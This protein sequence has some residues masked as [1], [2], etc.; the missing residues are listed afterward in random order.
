MTANS[1]PHQP[2]KPLITAGVVLGIGLG[3]FL[4][5]IVLHQ[6]LQVHGMLTARYPKD[7]IANLQINMF[8]DGIFHLVT[9]TMTVLGLWLLWRAATVH[10]VRMNGAV[11]VGAMFFGWGLFNLV[12]GIVDHH[13][14]HLHHVVEEHGVS[15]FDYAFLA[16]AVLMMVGGGLVI[17]RRSRETNP[18]QPG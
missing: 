7:S 4:D 18:S 9:W 5:G 11:L 6:I 10:R 3:G 13:V 16:T 17:R 15:L 8:W 14:L 2:D 12:E 1:H